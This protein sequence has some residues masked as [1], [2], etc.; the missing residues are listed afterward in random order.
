MKSDRN[1][2]RP[3]DAP[4]SHTTGQSSNFAEDV[5]PGPVCASNTKRDARGE[6]LR[7]SRH[8]FIQ[9]TASCA[10]PAWFSDSSRFK[11]LMTARKLDELQ[12]AFRFS[13]E[14]QL[15]GVKLL[16]SVFLLLL[17]KNSWFT[18]RRFHN[19]WRLLWFLLLHQRH[20]WAYFWV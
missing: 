18:T 14:M 8:A 4:V 3:Y 20:F 13:S 11:C 9:L 12:N 1:G 6:I 15:Q 19:L 2:V 10:R 7:A 5:M 16:L 17:R